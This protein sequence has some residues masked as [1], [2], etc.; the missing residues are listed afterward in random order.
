MKS[1]FSIFPILALFFILLIFLGNAYAIDT[2]DIGCDDVLVDEGS[3]R[4]MLSSSV[5]NTIISN[6]NGTASHS[7][8]SDA[9]DSSVYTNLYYEYGYN[10]YILEGNSF[11]SIQYAIDSV[12]ENSTIV[13]HGMDS[14]KVQS[15]FNGN[16][17]Q[18]VINK[19]ITLDG[20]GSTLDAKYLSRI[21]Y[22]T[23]N[24]V[25]LRNLNLINANHRNVVHPDIVPAS[26]FPIFYPYEY[27][28]LGTYG[29]SGGVIK[30]LGDD[31]CLKNS[32]FSNN[33]YA[34]FDKKDGRV[35]SWEGK[36]GSIRNSFF[37]T[38]FMIYNGAIDGMRYE[39]K[40]IDAP[41]YGDYTG[42]LI[43][44]NIFI[45]NASVNC[46]YRIH[47]N[48]ISR[49][50]G[51]SEKAS[52]NLTADDGF[53]FS[54]VN[55][56]L[57][58]SN[59]KISKVINCSSN[60][61]GIVN[62]NVNDLPVGTYDFLVK[63]ND[64][65]FNSTLTIEKAPVKFVLS[66]YKAAYD[67]PKKFNVKLLNSKDNSTVSGVKISLKLY[68]GKS[69]KTLTATTNSKGIASFSLSKNTVGKHKIIVSASENVVSAKKNS[70]ITITKASANVK[71]SKTT[72]KYKKSD[73][74][75]MTLTNKNTKKPISKL[76]VKVK[77]YTGKSYKTY[78][79]KTDKNG[80]IKINTKGLKK[81]SHKIVI[82][83]SS[84][85]YALSKT[86]AIKV[87]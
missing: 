53:V 61:Q 77:V 13:L 4:S 48:N 42:E 52:I 30:W 82:S 74:L 12:E 18:I 34:G 84:K 11:E 29:D 83:L 7:L 40:I 37:G 47:I 57:N 39:S 63:F 26:V 33:L 24:N 65:S 19:S 14:N 45:K 44:N 70:S 85:Y 16:G 62:F 55:T 35:I 31:G 10:S 6:A 23:A 87:K 69:Y 49:Y 25:T 54:N 46:D 22:I 15:N 5:D 3:S 67:S 28:T 60:S 8:E 9:N 58:I 68:T 1:K 59:D 66:S 21:F 81:G 75:K 80:I 51:N 56:Y 73:Y 20:L 36:G 38:N 79:L 71:L 2:E 86:A 50:F 27:Y 41:I 17:S 32:V 72:F 76:T 43:Y 78:S 64:F